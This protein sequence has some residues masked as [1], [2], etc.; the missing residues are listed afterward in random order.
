MSDATIG[1]ITILIAD[2]NPQILELL[3]AYLEP[4]SVRITTARDGQ[5]TLDAI[6]SQRPNLILLDVMMPRLSGFEV[7]RKLK[8]DRRFMDIPIIMVTALNELADQERASES[9]ADRFLTKPV[10]KYELLDHAR[11][12]LELGC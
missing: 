11:E 10:N 2:D 7:C 1:E 5:Q 3:E 8:Q 9:G 12:L 6:E 4:L